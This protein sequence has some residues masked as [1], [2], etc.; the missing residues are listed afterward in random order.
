MKKLSILFVSILLCLCSYSLVKGQE[1]KPFMTREFPASSIKEAVSTTSGGSI[2]VIGDAGSNAKV[3]V[4][5]SK[6]NWSSEKI[7]E[8][9][10]ENYTI[11]IKVESG[12]L[13]AVAKPKKTISNWN[14]QGLSISFKISVPKQ[15]NSN[16]QT[17]GGSINI[18]NMSG[19][20]N[21]KTSGG[22][23][24]IENVSGNT[25][26]ATSGGSINVKDSKDNID[27]KTSGGSITAK[28]CSGKISLKTSGGSINL[29]NLS[30]NINAST[31]GGS[32]TVND[33]TGT[34]ITSTSGGSMKL[35]GISGNV[36]ARTSGG[37]MDVKIKSAGDYVK[38]NNSG[39]IN[40]SLPV[41]KG[42]NLKVRSSNK[43]DVSGL[44]DFS[45][46]V[47]ERNIDGTVGKGGAE[48]N[49]Q[50]SQRVRLSFE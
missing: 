42:Y 27:L 7:K 30:G 10:D 19:S 44:K 14:T 38:L 20:Q 13:H 49:V 32:V 47:E 8:V 40:L 43:I 24:N 12:T 18:S 34:L 31:S 22:S 37:S 46:K 15:A 5:V 35:N 21:F 36:E 2:T 9:L 3:E 39:N 50:S 11:E 4:F 41:G 16:L 48:V 28:D 1:N 26:G 25:I 17:S 33:V 23:L 6:N 45:G 29:G